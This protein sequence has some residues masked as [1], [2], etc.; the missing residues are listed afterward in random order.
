[1][2]FSTALFALIGIVTAMGLIWTVTESQLVDAW[3]SEGWASEADCVNYIKQ[4]TGNNET[5][6]KY[7]CDKVNPHN[8]NESFPTSNW[9]SK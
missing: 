7:K 5:E 9:S 6:A 3:H 1:M 4:V 8:L 2:E